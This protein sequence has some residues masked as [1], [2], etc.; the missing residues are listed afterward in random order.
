M[1]EKPLIA[2]TQEAYIPGVSTRSSSA[3]SFWAGEGS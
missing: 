3:I 2:V 1:T